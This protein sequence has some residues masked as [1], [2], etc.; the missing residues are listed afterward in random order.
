MDGM[1]TANHRLV[2]QQCLELTQLPTA[3]LRLKWVAHF[4]GNAPKLKRELL[5]AALAYQL[6]VQA[7]GGLKPRARQQLRDA[8]SP[9]NTAAPRACA[10]PAGTRLVREWQGDTHVVEVSTD[11]YLWQGQKRG[12]LSAIAREITGTRWSGPR[13]FGLHDAKRTTSP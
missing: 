11:G 6:Q 1:K 12:S 3:D 2:A 10:L 13:F 4:G 9:A 8:L 5:L 7:L